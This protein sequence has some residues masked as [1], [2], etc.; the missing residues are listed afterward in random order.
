[1]RVSRRL[2][3]FWLWIIVSFFLKSSPGS[4]DTYL[5]QPSTVSQRP[6]MDETACLSG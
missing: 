1:M 6:K 4:A 3:I 5:C 2:Y